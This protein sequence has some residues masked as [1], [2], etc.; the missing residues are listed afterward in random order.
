MSWV[1]LDDN[2]PD[3]A[4][5]LAAGAAAGW[6]WV[7]G[8]AY[9][10]RQKRRDG[11]IPAAKVRTLYPMPAAKKCAENLEKVGLWERIEGGYRVHDYHDYQPTQEQVDALK[12]VRSRAGRL[13]GRSKRQANTKQTPSKHQ[14]V[15]KLPREANANP[16]PVPVPVPERTDLELSLASLARVPATQGDTLFADFW[17]A[18]P[19][20]VGKGDARKA[21]QTL[22]ASPAL[23]HAI[24]AALAWQRRQAQWLE[25]AGKFIPS[26]GKYL[27]MGRWEDEPMA[28]PILSA[29][30]ATTVAALGAWAQRRM[31]AD[32]EKT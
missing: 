11:F 19:K 5:I 28:G 6:L 30:S 17:A 24:L 23:L 31:A 12:A 25:G 2:F 15:E 4:K 32:K 8:L 18:Y 20:K 29:K 10:N 7:C 16:V 9:C 13:G 21:W 3:H 22:K 27:R 1:K 26:P 14:A